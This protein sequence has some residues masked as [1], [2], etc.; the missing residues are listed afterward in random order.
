L[1]GVADDSKATKAQPLYYW[2]R[3]QMQSSSMQKKWIRPHAVTR[4]VYNSTSHHLKT[5]KDK[6]LLLLAAV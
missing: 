3:S 1:L 6:P 5:P 4:I 2:L